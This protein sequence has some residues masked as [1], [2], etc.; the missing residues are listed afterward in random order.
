MYKTISKFSAQIAQGEISSLKKD[1]I[2]LS[3][4]AFLFRKCNVFTRF[5]F[6]WHLF[7]QMV[8]EDLTSLRQTE[9]FHINI[10]YFRE[11]DFIRILKTD[12]LA[13]CYKRLVCDQVLFRNIIKR[14]TCIM[15]YYL[16][17]LALWVKYYY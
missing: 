17:F 14:F 7:S 3:I 4:I 10:S 5:L 16:L 2:L 15:S 11:C 8:F 9:I 6:R 1:V 12:V 13:D